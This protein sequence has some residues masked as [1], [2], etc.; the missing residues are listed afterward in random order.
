MT[1]ERV[2]LEYKPERYMLF[3]MLVHGTSLCALHIYY[4]V[5]IGLFYKGAKLRKGTKRVVS[6]LCGII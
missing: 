4:R 2:V 5:H 6:H 3:S 1:Y